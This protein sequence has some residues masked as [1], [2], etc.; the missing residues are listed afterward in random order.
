MCPGPMYGPSYILLM[1]NILP[2]SQYM[3]GF[4]GPR[5]YRSGV[6]EKGWHVNFVTPQI[7]S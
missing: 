4:T 6:N 1:F 7:I 3:G 2:Q 5:G